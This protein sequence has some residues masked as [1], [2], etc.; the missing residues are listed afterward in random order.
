M[1]S[2][3]YLEKAVKKRKRKSAMI[4][5]EGAE[6][7]GLPPEPE[8]EGDAQVIRDGLWDAK[9]SWWGGMWPREPGGRG[10]LRRFAGR[11]NKTSLFAKQPRGR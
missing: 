2:K 9:S 6:V 1:G 10:I 5:E 11:N 4:E 3:L 7:W 8:S